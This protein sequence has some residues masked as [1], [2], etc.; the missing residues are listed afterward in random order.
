MS[1]KKFCAKCGKETSALIKGVCSDCYLEKRELFSLEKP[2]FSVCKTCGKFISHNKWFP[3]NEST[4]STDMMKRIRYDH[5]LV[6]P[7]PF[8]E[9]NQM[10]DS[11]VLSFEVV[12]KVQG[13]IEGVLVEEEKEFILRVKPT[14]CDACM[15]L[16]AN[17][18]EAVVQIRAPKTDAKKIYDA[19]LAMLGKEHVNN[20]LSGTSK[21]IDIPQG[22]DLWIGDKKVA[23]KMV[24]QLSKTFDLEIISSKKI[25]GEEG[26]RGNFIY[27]FTFCLKKK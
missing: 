15:K 13:F 23:T 11:E 4:I 26:G 18:R 27:R 20:S 9:V 6:D 2:T 8:V 3:L 19:A 24:R 14:T 7:K 16:N 25:I 17:Y 5:E 1:F 22:Y 21:V 12:V 10:V